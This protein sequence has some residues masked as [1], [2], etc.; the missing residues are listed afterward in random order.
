LWRD[1]AFRQGAQDMGAPSVGIAAWGL[2]TGVAMVKSGMPVSIALATSLLVFAGSAQLATMP[3]LA[4]SAPLWVIWATAICVNLRFVILSTQWRLYFG[5]LPQARRLRMAYFAADLN[6][7]LFMQR[8]PR[9]EPAPGQE[10]YFWGGVAV[11]YPAWQGASVA[12]ILLGERIPVH[13]GLGFAGALML[14]GLIGSMLQG[15]ATWVAA[16]VAAVVAVLSYG[17]PFKLNIVLAIAA[18]V[19]AGLVMD[20]FA[21]RPRP[22]AVAAT[23]TADECR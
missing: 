13:W 15:A 10:R 1:P 18:A 22:V 5:R 17:L 11:N 16:A 7:V 23:A 2:V 9:P 6:Y 8:H 21:P 4:A 19:A 14:I 12:G 3:L 20:R